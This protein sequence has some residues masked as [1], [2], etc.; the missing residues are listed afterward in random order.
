MGGVCSYWTVVVPTKSPAEAMAEQWLF[1]LPMGN[2][3]FARLDCIRFHRGWLFLACCLVQFCAGFI[4]SFM[5]LADSLDVYFYGKVTKASSR[6]MLLAY[7]CLGVSAALAGPFVER[8]GPRYAMVVGTVVVAW[9][10]VLSQLAISYKTPLLLLLGF[11]VLGGLGFGLLLIASIATVQKWYPDMRGAASGLCIFSFGVGNG[12]FIKA[13]SMLLNVPV[14]AITVV[15]TGQGMTKVF[16]TTGVFIVGVLVVC[17]LVLRTPPVS[18]TVKGKD[19][20]NV[21]THRAPNPSLV[22]DEYLNVGMTLVNYTVVQHELNGSD[23]FYF[24]QVKA[25]TLLQCIASTDFVCL[26]VAFT[27]NIMPILIFLPEIRQ[28]AI[29]IIGMQTQDQVN[30]FF[31]NIYVG[32]LGGRLAA[33]LLSD[34]IIRVS[35][36]NPAY[37]RKLMFLGLLFLQCLA[38]IFLPSQLHNPIAVQ[39]LASVLTSAA[40]GGLALIPCFITDMFG[41]YNAGTMYGVIWTCWTL[42]AVVSGYFLSNQLFSVESVCDQLYWMLILTGVGCGMMIFVRT[43]SMDRFFCGYQFSAFGKV[44][45]QVPFQLPPRDTILDLDRENHSVVTMLT[46]TSQDSDRGLILWNAETDG[47]DHENQAQRDFS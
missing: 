42:G 20:H 33:P 14:G 36:A 12:A 25:M 32:N 24:Q 2:N 8:R 18:Y 23:G 31:V 6:V 13:T 29:Q 35:Y 10:Q 34:L 27:A 1:A 30:S 19:I 7:V 21:D 46:P 43:N 40:G 4:Y 9:G 41:V 39:R 44:L 28:F 45:V 15:L 16:W 17:T 26:Y 22:Q 38:L 5:M 47:K 37:A 11:G 3:F